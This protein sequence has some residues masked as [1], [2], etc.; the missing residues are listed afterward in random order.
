MLTQNN[1]GITMGSNYQWE[2]NLG[3]KGMYTRKE[4]DI[5]PPQN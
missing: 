5:P 4:K 3:L 2:P 1:Y